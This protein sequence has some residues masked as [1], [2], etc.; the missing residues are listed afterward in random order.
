MRLQHRLLQDSVELAF[1][2]NNHSRLSLSG[3]ATYLSITA[4]QP[5]PYRNS[6][7]L[8]KRSFG[9]VEYLSLSSHVPLIFLSRPKES[10]PFL[11]LNLRSIAPLLTTQAGNV[12]GNL[13]ES[14]YWVDVISYFQHWCLLM[15][16]DHGPIADS[17]GTTSRPLNA[18]SVDRN[19]YKSTSAHL[20]CTLAF[21]RDTLRRHIRSG[22]QDCY[23]DTT[24]SP[25]TYPPA[26][27]NSASSDLR[28]CFA[29]RGRDHQ[30]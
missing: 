11:Y 10:E 15:S 27:V 21:C 9:L 1:A 23:S 26:L 14:S 3:A 2:R 17:T 20:H 8:R 28:F 19:M 7:A 12:P 6:A 22:H 29:I 16:P 25:D 13:D 24:G 30:T 5:M 4:I 18:R